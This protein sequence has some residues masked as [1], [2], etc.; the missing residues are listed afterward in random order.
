MDSI[1]RI[2]SSRARIYKTTAAK[3]AFA[4]ATILATASTGTLLAPSPAAAQSSYTAQLSGTVTD[5]SGGV[6][7]NA[8]VTLTDEGTGVSSTLNTDERGV[9]VFVGIRPSTYTI[10]VSATG[11][12]TQERK[13]VVL[14]VSQQA[15][16]DITLKPG[17]TTETVNVTYQA[18]LL[19]TTA[20]V[21]AQCFR[22][23]D[24]RADPFIEL[25]DSDG[26]AAVAG[27]RQVLQ[28]QRGLSH[29]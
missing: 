9:F 21:Q 10:N 5:S 19:D 13:G 27:G 2:N 11:L 4:F 14:A 7:P 15:N 24:E 25:I 23:A 3:F 18:P 12:N 29:P 16:I 28:S 17:A 22:S 8:K 20:Q 1:L 6:I 26:L